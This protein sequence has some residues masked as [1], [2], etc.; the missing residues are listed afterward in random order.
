MVGWEGLA[1][2]EQIHDLAAPLIRVELQRPPAHPEF[3]LVAGGVQDAGQRGQRRGLAAVLVRGQ[4]RVRCAGPLGER[5]Q[6]QSGLVAAFGPAVR[7]RPRG[8]PPGP[9]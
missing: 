5:P 1:E 3:E 7:G 9:R 6:G 4:R 2:F 8:C